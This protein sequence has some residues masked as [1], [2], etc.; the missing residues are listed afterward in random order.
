[1][2]VQN[3]SHLY[4]NQSYVVIASEIIF[5]NWLNNASRDHFYKAHNCLL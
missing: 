3:I 1:M 4:D 5:K 2:F